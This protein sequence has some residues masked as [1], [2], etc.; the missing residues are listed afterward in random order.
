LAFS[1]DGNV[2]PGFTTSGGWGPPIVP[3][4][5]VHFNFTETGTFDGTS[6]NVFDNIDGFA[7]RVG[8]WN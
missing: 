2:Y 6:Y 3:P 4:E 1:D 5:E 8:R 7:R